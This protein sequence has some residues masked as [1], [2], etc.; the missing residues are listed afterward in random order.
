MSTW[1]LGMIAPLLM[2]VHT[3]AWSQGFGPG[4]GPGYGAPPGRGFVQPSPPPWM[5]VPS[6]QPPAYQPMQTPR[7]LNDTPEYC[8]ELLDDISSLRMRVAAVPPTVDTLA[9]EGARLCQIGHYRP[10][11]MRLRTALML[12][13]H[14]R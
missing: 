9:S 12:L 13:R 10:G 1:R 4:G 2:A 11:I 3:Q 7:L 14:E 6:P 8:E 5:F